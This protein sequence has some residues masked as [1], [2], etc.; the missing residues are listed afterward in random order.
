MP[1]ATTTKT[2]RE[3][4]RWLFTAYFSDGSSIEQ[5]Q[6]DR[7]YT[8]DDGTGSTFTDV[9]AR[10]DL[11]K[12]ELTNDES[13]VLV[14]LITGAFVV[15]GVPLHAH[16][17]FFEPGKYPLELVYFRETRVDQVI[18]S[19]GEQV[20]SKQ[21]VNRYFVGWKTLVNGKYKQVTLAVG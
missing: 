16:N 1:Q 21:Y 3:A 8:R 5:D 2:E 15:N 14:D 7:C 13:S 4:L 9:L 6:D 18:N 17:Q 19:D 20:S 12:F 11:V 10:D